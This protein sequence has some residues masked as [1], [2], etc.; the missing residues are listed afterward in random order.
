MKSMELRRKFFKFFEQNGHTPVDS[1]SLIPAQDPTLLFTNAGMNQFKDLFLGNETCSYTRAVSIQKCIRAGGKHNDLENVGF[2]K[3]HLTF[4]EMM[5]NFSFGDYFKREAIQFAWNFLT[6]DIGLPKEKL[7]A[8]VHL[9]DDEAYDLWNKEIGIPHERMHRFDEDNFWQMGDT[10]PCGPCTEIFIDRGP[11]FGPENDFE[12]D[13]Y[14]EIWNLVF[15]QFN[16]QADGTDVPLKQTGVDTG[17][18][19]ERLALVVQGKDS[20]FDTDLFEPIFKGIKELTGADYYALEQGEQKSSCRV[21]ADH[22]RSSVLAI[23]DGGSPSN[24]GRGYVIRKIIRRAALFAQK[25]RDAQLFVDLLPFFIDSMK[26]IYPA[27]ESNQSRIQA[28]LKS[29]IDSFVQNLNRGQQIMQEYIGA[30]KDGK[31]ITGKQAFKLYDTFG[32]P[33]E[34]TNVIA[35]D[36]GYTVDVDGFH[37]EMKD[38]RKRSG[39]KAAFKVQGVD[40][41]LSQVTEFVGY[42]NIESQ[43][44]IT[45]LIVDGRT[46]ESVDANTTCMVV[47][48]KTPCYV[49]GGGQVSDASQIKLGDGTQASITGLLKIGKAIAHVATL[50]AAIKIGDTITLSVD[51]EARS[52]TMKNHTATHLL[53][54]ALVQ[55]LGSGVKQAGSL[56]EPGHLRFD[57]THHKQM[58]E[59]QIREVEALVNAKIM[60]NITLNVFETTYKD[61]TERGVVSFFGDKYNPDCVRV[62]DI[63]EF[64]AEL[65]GGTHVNATG[66]IGVFKIIEEGS[67]S[68]GI[69]R[70][71]GL[72]G[73]SAVKNYQQSFG[74]INRLGT[75]FK[76]QQAEILEAVERQRK[77]LKQAN[78]QAKKLRTQLVA[79]KLPVWLEK[80]ELVNDVP[81]LVLTLKGYDASSVRDIATKLNRGKPGLY[82]VVNQDADRS[83]FV[84]C[85]DA[86]LDAKITTESFS[87]L[88]SEHG[89][90][91]GGKG[92]TIQGGGELTGDLDKAIKGLLQA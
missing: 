59:D 68:A 18:G 61:A 69:R 80:V 15:M 13:R 75:D 11:S 12:T 34:L 5:G 85:K 48:D 20:V 82:V 79:A 35:L 33:L 45:A 70:I 43:A 25:L 88:L 87:K 56:V 66:D 78:N 46:V 28:V 39:G 3:R 71:V 38:Q 74:I 83:Q 76:V 62:I 29:E 31:H 21:L 52:N 72:T 50:P 6:N 92:S 58:S 90:R 8:T 1:S 77:Q 81:M 55:V 41:E 73:P 42:Q 65:C 2:T 17:M 91:G 19:L 40:V 60:E 67:L 14:L 63:G 27:L 9:S 54:A 53:Q 30:A 84:A 44:K 89:L 24:E 86:S 16:R 26:E 47:T 51:Q 4:F 64:S 22:M 57:F 49:E 32:F 10:G 23:S 37:A 7:H 36:H